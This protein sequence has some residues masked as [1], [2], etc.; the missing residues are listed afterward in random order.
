[1]RNGSGLPVKHTGA[2]EMSQWFAG[3]SGSI[4]EGNVGEDEELAGNGE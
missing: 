3:R 4:R 2:S 1:V